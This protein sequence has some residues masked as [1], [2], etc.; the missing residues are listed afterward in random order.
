MW[1]RFAI[2][3]AVAFGFIA[4][5]PV[6][7]ST[8]PATFANFHAPLG[9]DVGKKMLD[10]GDAVLEQE[11]FQ[12]SSLNGHHWRSASKPEVYAEYRLLDKHVLQ[13]ALSDAFTKEQEAR[14]IGLLHSRLESQIGHPVSTF[15]TR[16]TP[17]SFSFISV[18]PLRLAIVGAVNFGATWFLYLF[19]IGVTRRVFAWR[20]IRKLNTVYAKDEPG[21]Y[22][23]LLLMSLPILAIVL[24][25]LVMAQRMI[26]RGDLMVL[27]AL[28]GVQLAWAIYRHPINA[29]VRGGRYAVS[30]LIAVC[31]T[32]LAWPL[33][34]A[35]ASRL[36][37]H[38]E[39]LIGRVDIVALIVGY[40]GL[41]W[42]LQ[43]ATRRHRH[44]AVK[45]RYV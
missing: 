16:R 21:T 14:I 17:P 7:A 8:P 18:S 26:L 29:R 45:P 5:T 42:L 13:M 40:A 12:R 43:S 41:F 20:R 36:W 38:P 27:M 10:V 4:S 28:T 33:A 32:C 34:L 3:I 22:T 31:A 37:S 11:G 6:A 39:Q 15:T 23:V 9:M 19:Y 2:T 35:W 30:A 1:Q 44:P 25:Y 24:G